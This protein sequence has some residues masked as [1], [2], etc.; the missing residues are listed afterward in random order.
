M[1]IGI[2]G[3][4]GSGKSIVSKILIASNYTVFNSDEEAKKIIAH[5][6]KVQQEIVGLFGAESFLHGSYNRKFIGEKIFQSPELKEQ[7]NEIVHPVVRNEF[8]KK[9]SVLPVIFNEAAIFFETGTYKSFDKM[10]LV[11][12]PKEIRIQRIMKRDHLTLPEIE[13]RMGSQ[14]LDE[15]KRA[16]TDFELINDGQ[17]SVLLQLQKILNDLSI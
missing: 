12:A 1:R 3:G 16:L 2:T 15:Q 9:A 7:L 13:L 6:T 17:T 11:T 14:W 4:I 10:I 8:E 5:N